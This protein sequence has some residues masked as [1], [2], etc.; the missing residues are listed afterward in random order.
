VARGVN[1]PIA[2][3]AT[4]VIS[5]TR[6]IPNALDDVID[7]LDDVATAGDRSARDTTDALDDVSRQASRTADDVGDAARD[8]TTDTGDAADRL[9]RSFKDSFDS[10]RTDSRRAGDDLGSNVRRGADEASEGVDTLK[11]NAGSNAKEIAASFDGS[12]ESMID[13]IQGFVAEATEGF[14]AVGLAAG[15]GVGA[16]IGILSTHLQEAAEKANELTENAGEMALA[17]RDSTEAERAQDLADRFDE[18][19]TSIADAKSWWEVWQSRAVTQAEFFAT[20]IRE[21]AISADDLMAAFNTTDPVDRLAAINKALDETND[22]WKE[23]DESGDPGG[24]R[25]LT[26]AQEELYKALDHT[27]GALKDQ[28]SELEQTLTILDA[29][30]EQQGMTRDEYLA[31]TD[32]AQHAAEVQADYA[33]SLAAM[34]DPI[35]AYQTILADKTAA[36]QAAAQATADATEDSADSWEDYA[37]AATVTMADLISDLNTKITSNTQFRENLRRLAQRGVDDGFIDELERQ[38]PE[39]AGE[40][41]ALLTKATDDELT[42]YLQKRAVMMGSKVPGAIGDGI[43]ANQGRVATD[44]RSAIDHAMSTIP[45][46]SIRVNATADTSTMVRQIQTQMRNVTVEVPIVPRVGRVAY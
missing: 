44:V 30:A 12:A 3:D 36:E 22:L 40:M 33:E 26:Y 19:A 17:L 37:K 8:I 6:K 35:D 21:G 9:E 23:L 18:V 46:P 16:A 28:R 1:I 31:T 2:A 41:T 43:K 11:E 42:Q 20:A 10:V 15:I 29:I 7:A 5:E 24:P 13:G 45:T 4:Q 14:G 32:A 34:A 27:R 25:D 39:V 38:G